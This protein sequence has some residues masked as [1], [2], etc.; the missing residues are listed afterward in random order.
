MSNNGC[1]VFENTI[2]LCSVAYG[3]WSTIQQLWIFMLYTINYV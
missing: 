2:N 3:Y 1:L